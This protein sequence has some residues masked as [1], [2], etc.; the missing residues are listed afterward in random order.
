MVYTT[1]G[2]RPNCLEATVCAYSLQVYYGPERK[3]R[4]SL[5]VDAVGPLLLIP[6]HAR[7]PE[8]MVG[9]IGHVRVT[10]STR[11][12][13]QEGTIT[14]MR[15]QKQGAMAESEEGGRRVSSQRP[16]LSPQASSLSNSQLSTMTVDDSILSQAPHARM[17]DSTSGWRAN[18]DPS[19]TNAVPTPWRFTHPKYPGGGTISE[20]ESDSS[21]FG[22]SMYFSVEEDRRR[23][24]KHL[25]AF[26]GPCLLDCI[27]IDLTEVDV[28]SATRERVE[29]GNF[30]FLRQVGKEIGVPDKLTYIIVHQSVK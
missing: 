7:S 13:G 9:D 26:R 24:E 5:D 6:K 20:S 17:T 28:F 15:K 22:S 27:E 29:G 12:D 10:N 11:Y 1:G 18:S 8:M 4:I 19:F 3:A 14:F 2:L 21:I 23:I 25:D 16:K 30:K